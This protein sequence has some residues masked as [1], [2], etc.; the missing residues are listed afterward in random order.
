MTQI[1]RLKTDAAEAAV[2]LVEN[3][4][5]V[6]LGPGSTASLA[7]AILPSHRANAF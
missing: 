5:V 4:Q 7:V 2:A 1:D 3:G 6:G